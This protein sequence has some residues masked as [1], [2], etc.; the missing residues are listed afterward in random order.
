MV[1]VGVALVGLVV[2]FL[3]GV[4]FMALMYMVSNP[5]PPEPRD[6]RGLEFFVDERKKK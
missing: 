6:S 3:G 1:V 2:G 5:L 4:I